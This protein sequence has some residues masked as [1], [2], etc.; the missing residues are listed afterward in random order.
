MLVHLDL[1]SR[2]VSKVNITARVRVMI[3]MHNV[4]SMVNVYT[5]GGLWR[6]TLN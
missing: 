4:A 3:R 2:L 5:A 1:I 6:M